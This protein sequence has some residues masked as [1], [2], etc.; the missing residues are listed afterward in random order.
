MRD[1]WAGRLP[2]G[3]AF[4][5]WAL[6]RGTLVNAAATVAALAV[7]AAG[8]PGA[9]AAAIFFLPLPYTILATVGTL[10]SARHDEGPR[11]RVFAIEVAVVL[12]AVAM[13]LL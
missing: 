11:D 13:V 7:L 3:V 10:R 1:L 4:W 9:V 12:W 8:G 6:F 5:T 2:L